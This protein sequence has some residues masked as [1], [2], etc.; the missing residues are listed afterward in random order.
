[1]STIPVSQSAKFWQA[2]EVCA[3]RSTQPSIP[4]RMGAVPFLSEQAMFTAGLHCEYGTSTL[5]LEDQVQRSE[6]GL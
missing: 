1:M 4:V 5:V 2:T 6:N 3:V